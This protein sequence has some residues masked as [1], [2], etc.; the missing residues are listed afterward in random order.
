MATADRRDMECTYISNN[1]ECRE[2][3]KEK[4]RIKL[5]NKKIG[6]TDIQKSKT[7]CTSDVSYYGLNICI[8]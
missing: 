8:R 5:N 1:K 7:F 4:K 3:T 2:G 6:E